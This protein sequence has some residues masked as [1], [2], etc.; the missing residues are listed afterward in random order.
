MQFQDHVFGGSERTR[1]AHDRRLIAMVL[2]GQLWVSVFL[3]VLL[4]ANGLAATEVTSVLDSTLALQSVAVPQ[5]A[6]DMSIPDT[7]IRLLPHAVL[8]ITI[9]ESS[10]EANAR[11]ERQARRTR[12]TDL[13]RTLTLEASFEQKRALAQAAAAA[14]G[15]DWKIL[16]AVW[17]VE[18]GKRWQT[19]V[20][21]SA[22]AQGPM[23]FMPGTWRTYAVDGNSD[24]TKDVHEAQDAVYAGAKYLAAN[25]AATNIDRA[26]L[27]YNHAQWYVQKVKQ[28]AAS[29]DA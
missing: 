28:L 17:Q 9:V 16:E 21:S 29:I 22:G 13:S 14:Y 1:Q 5:L 2:L 10:A 27:A 18:S 6:L 12:V 23:Q 8:T 19:T 20:R 24:G 11:T 7:P 26:L 4:P 3:T 15:I 25:G